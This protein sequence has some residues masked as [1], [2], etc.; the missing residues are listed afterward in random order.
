[1]LDA[2]L[3]SLSGHRAV[4]SQSGAPSSMRSTATRLITARRPEVSDGISPRR[5]HS[6]A[7]VLEIPS[8]PAV[9]VTVYVKRSIRCSSVWLRRG[10]RIAERRARAAARDEK[11]RGRA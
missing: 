6:Y 2:V 4:V 5:T 9:W 10:C 7:L 3:W 1:M 8:S 11:C